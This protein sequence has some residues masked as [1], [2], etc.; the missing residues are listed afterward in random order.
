MSSAWSASERSVWERL[1]RMEREHL[2]P[3]AKDGFDLAA[4][5]F[6]VVNTQRLREGA[7][8]LRIRCRWRRAR[9]WKRRST[10]PMWRSGGRASA[11]RG[12]SVASGGNRRCSI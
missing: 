12:M 2:L 3:L 11:W 8:E 1:W 4:V 6:P 7:D 9:R 10:R 5:R